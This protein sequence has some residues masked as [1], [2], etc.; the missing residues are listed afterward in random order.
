M[1]V[2]NSETKFK[3]KITFTHATIIYIC[4]ISQSKTY[5]YELVRIA[6]KN[7]DLSNTLAAFYYVNFKARKIVTTT[8]L[9]SQTDSNHGDIFSMQENFMATYTLLYFFI[10]ILCSQY[11]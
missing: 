2:K 6:I 4:K 11:V 10:Y 8:K 3:E 7:K 5:G 1:N 9:T